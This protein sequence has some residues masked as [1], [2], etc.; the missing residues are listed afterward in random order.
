[1]NTTRKRIALTIS[2]SFMIV[3]LVVFGYFWLTKSYSVT[4][5]N[6][7]KLLENQTIINQSINDYPFLN[8]YK[9]E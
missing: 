4:I 1:M 7:D 8:W 3:L 5:Y 6:E 9:Q 2:L